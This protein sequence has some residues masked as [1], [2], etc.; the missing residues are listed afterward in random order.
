MLHLETLP[1]ATQIARL[2]ARGAAPA[3]RKR[4]AMNKTTRRA[5]PKR[6]LRK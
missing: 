1:D 5:Q 6:T 4:A 2:L 3:R